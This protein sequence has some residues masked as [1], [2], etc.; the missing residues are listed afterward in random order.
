MI[1]RAV[2]EAWPAL[3]TKVDHSRNPVDRYTRNRS[4]AA[5]GGW[6]TA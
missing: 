6:K 2:Y 3:L 1:G 5:Q 4:L